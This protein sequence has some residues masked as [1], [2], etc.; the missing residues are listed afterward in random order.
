MWESWLWTQPTDGQ[1]H[2]VSVFAGGHVTFFGL[3]NSFVHIIMYTYYML[4]ALGPSVQK[5]LW[6]KKHVTTL[7]LVSHFCVYRVGYKT[8]YLLHRCVQTYIG[9]I[10]LR[11]KLLVVGIPLEIIHPNVSIS[12]QV[13][14]GGS[15][16]RERECWRIEHGKWCK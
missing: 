6:W 11:Y 13:L 14:S 1:V 7:Q 15:K 10:L 4:A 16:V 5:Y 2:K 9:C 12:N 8:A 3:I